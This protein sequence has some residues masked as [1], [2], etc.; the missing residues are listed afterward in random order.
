M[1]AIFDGHRKWGIW[2]GS[3]SQ[4][5]M[6]E[7]EFKFNTRKKLKSVA[8]ELSDIPVTAGMS[9]SCPWWTESY[10]IFSILAHLSFIY[11]YSEW[12]KQ[13]RKAHLRSVLYTEFEQ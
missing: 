12:E 9:W 13:M 11:T 10:L 1:G 7:V 6:Q 5:K 2:E 3:T 8:S 4:R